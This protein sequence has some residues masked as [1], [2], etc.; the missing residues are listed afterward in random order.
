M[1]F[2]DLIASSAD[3]YVSIAVRLG[4]DPAYR[5]RCAYII[6]QLSQVIWQRK[7]VSKRQLNQGFD[8]LSVLL[9]LGNLGL[10]DLFAFQFYTINCTWVN[11][12]FVVS[13]EKIVMNP[14]A[15]ARNLTHMLFALLFESISSCIARSLPSGGRGVGTVP[16][17]VC[18]LLCTRP[19]SCSGAAVVSTTARR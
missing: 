2:L 16:P 14:S 4:L 13:Y 10:L 19:E 3:E 9:C 15:V 17:H 6:S 7:E 8:P 5:K 1:G 18:L 12:T 11:W